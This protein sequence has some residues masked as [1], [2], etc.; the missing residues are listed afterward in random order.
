MHKIAIV[1]DT[2]D[3]RDFLYYLLRDEF[4]VI[5]YGSGEEA[6]PQFE[7]DLPDLIVLDIRLEGMDGVDVLNRVRQDR[8]L[9]SVPVIA[10]TAHA[11]RGDRE[12]YLSA[13]FNAYFSKPIIDIDNFIGSIRSLLA[14]SSID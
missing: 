8:R 10:L 4:V 7:N 5:R 3:N 1:D 12:K 11:M 14:A 6:L 13:G 2:Q 9:D